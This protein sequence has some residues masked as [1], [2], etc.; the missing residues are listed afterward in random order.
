M[1]PTRRTVLLAGLVSIAALGAGTVTLGLRGTTRI[2]VPSGLV[3][4]SD[5]E[6]SI[7]SAIADTLHP[8]SSGLPTGTVA[9][10]PV[11]LDHIVSTMN[12]ADQDEF[13][14]ALGLIE[15]ALVGALLDQ[16]T[17]TFTGSSPAVRTETLRAWQNSRVYV[18]R[19]AFRALKGLCAGA[20]WSQPEMGHLAGYPGPIDYGQSSATK[21]T[22]FALEVTP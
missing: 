20:Y 16:R 2:D 6:Y 1:T 4:F 22:T 14:Q 13:R 8:G 17:T 21:P 7:L 5:D 11:A 18:R 15:N 9:G 19:Q 10:V 3:V 12:P